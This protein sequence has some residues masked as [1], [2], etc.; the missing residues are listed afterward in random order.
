MNST[1]YVEEDIIMYI[2]QVH[3]LYIR[4][5]AGRYDAI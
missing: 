4:R 3:I 5:Q 1:Y 2:V